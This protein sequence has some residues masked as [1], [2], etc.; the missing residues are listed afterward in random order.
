M[1]SVRASCSVL[2]RD[3]DH[4]QPSDA[5][6]QPASSVTGRARGGGGGGGGGPARLAERRPVATPPR[7]SARRFRF[8]R[9]GASP[10][11]AAA[12]TGRRAA[13]T[14]PARRPGPGPSEGAAAAAF[15][16]RL[17][18]ATSNPAARAA[19]V[20]L[21]IICP[22]RGAAAPRTSRL[23]NHPGSSGL[24]ELERPG[25]VRFSQAVS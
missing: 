25:P 23:T 16:R 6:V 15:A 12:A 9:L 24:L 8:R 19:G 17:S 10:T 20:Y 4:D 2:A 22:P 14:W 1:R 3:R 21:Q 13:R 18:S 11:G 5:P 7:C